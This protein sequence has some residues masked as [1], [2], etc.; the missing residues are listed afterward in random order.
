MRKVAVGLLLLALVV[1]AVTTLRPTPEPEPV[2]LTVGTGPSGGVYNALGTGLQEVTAATATPVQARST[3]ASV[4][5]IRM[6]HTGQI[7]A[8]FT[9]ADVAALAVAGQGPFGQ[10]QDVRAVARMYDNHTHLVVRAESGYQQVEDLAGARVSVG[11]ADSGTEMVANRLLEAAGLAAVEDGG[12]IHRQQLDL[13]DSA[14]A[15]QAEEIDAFFWS[16]GLP[17]GAVTRLAEETPVRLID[18]SVHVPELS[19][20]Y[21]DYFTELPIPAGT[22]PGVPA[23]RTI[24][25]PSLL[26]VHPDMPEE[27]AF[28]LTRSLFDSREDLAGFHPVM[29][30]LSARSAVATLPVELHPGAVAYYRSVKYGYDD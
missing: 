22:Y 29:L 26:V 6:V 3:P 9:L 11:A 4:A 5:N 10:V 19:A 2:P 8:G 14:A 28:E 27:V 7:E 15:L 1:L 21:G 16:G 24:G 12:D 18:L 13:E 17:T 25:V 23:V 30:Q 20:R